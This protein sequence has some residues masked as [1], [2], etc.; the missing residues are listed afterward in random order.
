MTNFRGQPNGTQP[1]DDHPADASPFRGLVCYQHERRVLA[2]SWYLSGEIVEPHYY[3][4]L[5]HALRVAEECDQIAIHLN[6]GGG[7]FDTGLQ[8]INNMQ[9]SRAHVI[10]I[11]EARAYS[12]GALIFLAGDEQMVHDNCQM[13]F[14]SY[15]ISMVARG[16]EQQAEATAMGIWFKRFMT[17]TCTP[18]LS[19]E[20]IASILQGADLW[21]DSDE[22]RHRLGH[23]RH[24]IRRQRASHGEP[25]RHATQRAKGTAPSPDSL[26]SKDNTPGA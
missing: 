26:S 8:I 9:A 7:D 17:R 16:H 3:L 21:M 20:E 24:A 22:I 13:L 15:S 11:L 1:D 23:G 19:G 4:D 25:D 14:H 12:M 10:T 5:F 6:T 18:F 2:Q